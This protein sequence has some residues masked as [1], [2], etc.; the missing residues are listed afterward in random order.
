MSPD[1]AE[2]RLQEAAVQ[3][4]EPHEPMQQFEQFCRPI[5]IDHRDALNTLTE[6]TEAVGDQVGEVA[7]QLEKLTCQGIKYDAANV[8]RDLA[9]TQLTTNLNTCS[10]DLRKIFYDGN[11]DSL[12]SQVRTLTRLVDETATKFCDHQEDHRK[13]SSSWRMALQR[14]VVG[15][16]MAF[17]I[18]ASGYAVVGWQ[19]SVNKEQHAELQHLINE[20][21]QT[22]AASAGVTNANP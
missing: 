3:G 1:N 8:A 19:R 16:A 21:R 2:K 18:A 22:N 20:F 4:K 7:G 10:A 11:G 12:M 15:L 17:I 14:G 13:A 9:L 6:T 5:L